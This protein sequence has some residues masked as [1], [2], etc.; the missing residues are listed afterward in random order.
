MSIKRTTFEHCGVKLEI[1]SFET[2]KGIGEYHIMFH[3]MHPTDNFEKQLNDIRLAFEYIL[4][5]Y[6]NV[7]TVFKRY[8]LSDISNQLSF[9]DKEQASFVQQPPL[10]G[11]KIVLWVYLQ[12][13][14]ENSGYKHLYT[15]GLYSP[16]S[17][18]YTQTETILEKYADE[19]K[20]EEC[21]IENDCIRTW[22]FINNIDINY[23]GVVNARKKFFEKHN[24]TENTHYIASTGIEGKY[25][26]PETF[27]LFDSYAV[28]GLCETQKQFL[29]A[30]THLSP[31]YKYGVTF[32][33]GI[34]IDYGDRSHIFISGT[35][36]IDNMGE[37]VAPGDICKQAERMFE[38]IN[39]LLC[40]AKSNFDNIAQMIVYIRDIADYQIVNKICKNRL[41]SIPHVIVLAPVCRP[42]WLIE[43]E[44]IAVRNNDDCRFKPL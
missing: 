16:N 40:E 7:K 12:S 18:S 27:V 31:T 13:N 21:T 24:L 5:R 34:K 22:F 43:A 38:N 37:I 29:Y 4:S 8:F 33:R 30:P 28:K 23:G 36:S 19:L 15:T 1:S 11:S 17:D 25:V 32:E 39:A 26:N 42:G 9:F 35:A 3:V 14:C 44:C 10:D 6:K 2:N 41:V 20:K